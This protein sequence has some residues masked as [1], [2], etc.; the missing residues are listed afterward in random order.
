VI[1]RNQGLG[2]RAN[3][4][5]LFSTSDAGGGRFNIEDDDEKFIIED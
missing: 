2:S 1:H 3:N 5:I 4:D